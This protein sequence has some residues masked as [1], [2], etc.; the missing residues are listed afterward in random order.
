MRKLNETEF[1]HDDQ[2]LN[3]MIF[4]LDG[5]SLSSFKRALPKTFN[6]LSTFD[7][8]FLFEKHHV[9]GENTI[10]NL[11]PL[12][13]NLNYIEVNKFQNSI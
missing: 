4:I 11:M 1:K 10:Q 7:E 9:T 5:V 2:K 12:L 6:Y 13:S 8:F 3:V